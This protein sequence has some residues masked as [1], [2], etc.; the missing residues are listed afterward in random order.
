M[1]SQIIQE[2]YK[3]HISP[4][5]N[6]DHHCGVCLDKIQDEGAL[7]CFHSFCINCILKWSKVIL[8]IKER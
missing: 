1:N 4:I 6:L 2:E 3:K 8:L 5:K 7:E